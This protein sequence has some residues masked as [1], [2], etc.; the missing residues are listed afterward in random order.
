MGI[1][2]RGS[3]AK[4]IKIGAMAEYADGVWDYASGESRPRR[5]TVTRHERLGLSKDLSGK[6]NGV[7]FQA[8]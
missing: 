3:F 1:L 6:T 4:K 7:T 8:A 5:Y 2:E